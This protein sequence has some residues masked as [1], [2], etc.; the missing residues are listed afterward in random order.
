MH[1]QQFFPH[2]NN[3]IRESAFMISSLDDLAQNIMGNKQARD[4][5]E[6]GLLAFVC[7]RVYV[8]CTHVKKTFYAL[9]KVEH[10]LR[11]ALMS[12]YVS[13]FNVNL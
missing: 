1:S 5:K 3:G 7:S 6:S 13:A 2:C 4:D 11:S 10:P 8:N 9:W 12:I